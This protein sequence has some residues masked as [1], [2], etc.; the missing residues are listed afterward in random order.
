MPHKPEGMEYRQYQFDAL[1]ACRENVRNKVS[2][3]VLQLATGAGKTHI[4]EMIAKGAV[5][6]GKRVYF[7][8]DQLELVD[9]TAQRF[10][11]SGLPVGVIQGHHEWTD[12]G[13]AV[14]VAT[15]QTLRHRWNRIIDEL[16]PDVVIID[17]CHVVHKAHVKMID[18]CKANNVPVIGLSATPFKR[19]LGNIFETLVVGATTADLTPMYL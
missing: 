15:I 18:D 1:E 8:V 16:K 7:V 14:Q 12:Y 19:G 13:K 11:D 4:A 9:Q 17:E 6:K 5:A 10:H 3:Q 2:T